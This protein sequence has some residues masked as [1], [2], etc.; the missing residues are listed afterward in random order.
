MTCRRPRPS[1]IRGIAWALPAVA[2]GYAIPF[3]AMRGAFLV[4][5]YA[6]G[7]PRDEINDGLLLISERMSLESAGTGCALVFGL[8]A[9]LNFIP[10]VRLGY[11][12]AV[13]FVGFSVLGGL[14][15]GAFTTAAFGL[16]PRTYDFDPWKWHRA[17]V[18]LAMPVAYTLI[19]TIQRC[20]GPKHVIEGGSADERPTTEPPP[21]PSQSGAP[22]V[23]AK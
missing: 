3:V 7:L 22:S 1:I 5:A 16:R 10:P 20:L 4:R 21:E 17:L 2:I 14:F 19:H 11:V 23:S 12:R 18:T 9:M 6:V 13:M 15:F 8:A